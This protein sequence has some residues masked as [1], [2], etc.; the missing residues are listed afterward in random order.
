MGKANEE[1][2][3]A[4]ISR[5]PALYVVSWEESRVDR[6]I[7]EIATRTFKTPLDTYYWSAGAGLT[8]VEGKTIDP[9]LREPERA[10]EWSLRHEKIAY[11]I[12]HDLHLHWGNPVVIRLVREIYRAFS[13]SYR[14]L[15]MLS[16]RLHLP[17]E[18]EKEVMV[19]DF[20]LPDISD[21]NDIFAAAKD[22]FAKSQKA[23]IKAPD[24]ICIKLLHAALG[25]TSDEARNAYQLAMKPELDE[26][27]VTAVLKEKQQLIRKSGVLE[28]VEHNF[29]MEDV[30]GLENLKE[31]LRKRSSIFKQEALDFGLTPPKGVLMT[32]ISGC[33][34]SLCVQAIAAFWQL[35]L[36]RLDLN[37]VYAGVLN[38]PEETLDRALRVAET[39]S[40]C[41][42]W[43]DEIEKGVSRT[44]TGSA[45]G[46]T[47]RIFSRFLTWM[48]EK[49]GL[50]F[51]AATANEIDLLAPEFLRKGRFDEIFFV[52]LP[53]EA[54]RADVFGV[55]L[56][57]RKQ[58]MTRFNLLNLAKATNNFSGSE[59]E[60]VTVS[61]MFDAYD[62][63]R[64]LEEKDLFQAI[65]RTIPL[66]T[67]M[68]EDIK[69][70]KRWALDRAVKASK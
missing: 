67:T 39:M 33:G 68:A 30:G 64:H 38:N 23:G 44:P 42:L 14:R 5:M 22:A 20:P 27:S 41:V 2:R 43:I 45:I 40:P 55:H 7:A 34:K 49:A 15:I 10:L 3:A 50:V 56:K 36:I 57:K 58:D 11:H 9:K 48:Q 69:K 24:A 17:V 53:T 21:L 65:G 60:Q 28:Y 16:P 8:G 18:L 25:L 59:I 51:I 19:F 46:P 1:L 61:G 29:R 63:K 26:G 32:G 47:A 62:Q 13:G 70:V 4:L 31:W 52:D 37:L 6:A 35:P 66:A 12:Y 54:E